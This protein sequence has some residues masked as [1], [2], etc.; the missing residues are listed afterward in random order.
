MVGGYTGIAT[1]LKPLNSTLLYINSQN[2]F[3]KF[4]NTI[5]NGYYYPSFIMLKNG[6]YIIWGGSNMLG[7]LASPEMLVVKDK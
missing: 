7:R 6:N 2:K 5:Y 1:S 4:K 3:L